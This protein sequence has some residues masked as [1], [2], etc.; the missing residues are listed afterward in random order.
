MI[1]QGRTRHVP[2]SDEVSVAL[3][4]LGGDGPPLIFVHA[5]GFHGYCYRRIAEYLHDIRRCLALDLRGHGDSTMPTNGRFEWAGMVDDLCAV[6]DT[7]EIAEPIDF[8]GHSLGGAV[9]LNTELRRPGTIRRAWLFEPIVFPGFDQQ[10]PSP[11]AQGA[12]KR[13]ATFESFD[14]AIARYGSRPPFNA[15]DPLVLDDYVRFGFRPHDDGVTLKCAPESEAATFENADGTLFDRVAAINADIRLVGSTDGD[16]PATFAPRAAEQ[17][18]G[19]VYECWD[20][21][22]HFGPF[23]RPGR[24]AEGIRTVIEG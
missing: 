1:G 11:L 12:R 3:H 18:P 2:S 9:I 14:A 19:A 22:T 20:G 4:D 23:T 16:A 8:V 6:L 10:S 15:I 13:R 5:T 17:I 7:L 21:E 24:A